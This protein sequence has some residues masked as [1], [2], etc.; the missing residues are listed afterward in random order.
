MIV[1]QTR[2]I[3]ASISILTCTMLTAAGTLTRVLR[4]D[5][6]RLA[7]MLCASCWRLLSAASPGFVGA[8]AHASGRAAAQPAPTPVAHVQ[9][10]AQASAV[11]CPA[12]PVRLPPGA[13][14]HP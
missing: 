12:A 6:S 3:G 5:G 4:L 2:S 7:G 14:D 13:R 9:S 11:V 8:I 1:C 10:P